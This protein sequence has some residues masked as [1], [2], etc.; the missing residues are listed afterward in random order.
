MELSTNFPKNM[1]NNGSTEIWDKFVQIYVIYI[2][3]CVLDNSHLRIPLRTSLKTESL[4]LVITTK[5]QD[6]G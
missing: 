1:L 6:F 4:V 2:L 5:Y 3:K